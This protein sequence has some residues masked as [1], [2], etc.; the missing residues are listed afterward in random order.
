M[1]HQPGAYLREL[2]SKLENKADA[3]LAAGRTRLT[4][5]EKRLLQLGFGEVAKK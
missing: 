5:E 4:E 3:A 2:T 1:H